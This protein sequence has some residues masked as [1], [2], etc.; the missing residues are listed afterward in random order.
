MNTEEWSRETKQK[1]II[2]AMVILAA[3]V[4]FAL[5]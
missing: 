1:V 5:I 4:F 3:L 2:S